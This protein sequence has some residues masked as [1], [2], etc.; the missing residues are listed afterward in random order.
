[1]PREP[2]AAAIA[3]SMNAEADARRTCGTTRIS[4]AGGGGGRCGGRRWTRRAPLARRRTGAALNAAAQAVEE[5]RARR[6]RALRGR[7][8][9][10]DSGRSADLRSRAT[11]ALLP[12]VARRHG[13]RR[14]D[15]SWQPRRRRGA[16]R[17]D[18]GAELAGLHVG[19]DSRTVWRRFRADQ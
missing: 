1:W 19:C 18:V 8:A 12:R 6:A 11:R 10:R 15:A 3:L 9:P 17:R 16:R 4:Y 13:Q 14:L 2:K 7:D 5:C